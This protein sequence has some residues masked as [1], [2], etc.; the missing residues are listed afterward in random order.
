MTTPQPAETPSSSLSDSRPVARDSSVAAE[1]WWAPPVVC[2][3][4]HRDR[5]CAGRSHRLSSVPRRRPRLR[6]SASSS[7][8]G[9]RPRGVLRPAI[10]QPSAGCCGRGRGCVGS[11]W[12]WRASGRPSSSEES[13]WTGVVSQRLRCCI[14]GRDTEGAQDYVLLELTAAS[15]GRQFLGAHS[16]HLN[17]VLAEGFVVEV[18]QE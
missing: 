2:R 1:D 8:P 12:T 17:A 14:C 9:R 13:E 11:A 7:R 15:D 6:R 4:G 3:G 16:K 18:R 5:R 10:G